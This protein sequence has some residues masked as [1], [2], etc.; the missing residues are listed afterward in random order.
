MDLFSDKGTL[1]HNFAQKPWPHS[2]PSRSN[3]SFV[4]NLSCPK[5]ENR[6]EEDPSIEGKHE[7]HC[8]FFSFYATLGCCALGSTQETITMTE[9]PKCPCCQQSFDN[10]LSTLSEPLLP[11]HQ[12]PSLFSS[13]DEDNS[14]VENVDGD[15]LPGT[16][17][18]GI[19]YYPTSVVVQG[20]LHKKGTGNDWLGNTS[21]KARWARM[22]MAKVDGY[23]CEVPLLQLYW[24]SSAPMPSTVILLESTVVLAMDLSDKDQWDSSQFEI[25]HAATKENPTI[26]ATRIFA[27]PKHS[28][29]VWVYMISE[30][31]FSFEKN[32]A[33]HKRSVMSTTR[34]FF[35]SAPL[36]TDD[37]ILTNNVPR[38][39]SP[40]DRAISAVV[41]LSSRP[42]HLPRPQRTNRR[43]SK[44]TNTSR[45]LGFPRQVKED[46]EALPNTD[47]STVTIEWYVYPSALAPSRSDNQAQP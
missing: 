35:R 39:E 4:H 19:K 37:N 41:G 9:K 15:L 40:V 45:G 47:P 24:H 32:M 30:A 5:Q 21:W 11:L 3:K 8:E 34:G 1:E 36:Q 16:L 18:A 27:A 38:K 6:D 2:M 14:D 46:D 7:R 17:T 26:S 44:H 22:I 31:L 25:R 23:N 29:D 20:W 12:T 43:S 28:R 33:A 13:S 42:S 10:T